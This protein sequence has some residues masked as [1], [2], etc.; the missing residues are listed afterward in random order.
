M[1]QRF[2]DQGVPAIPGVAELL[3]WLDA[4][5]IL[6]AVASNAPHEKMQ[7]T[8]GRIPTVG[9]P[10]RRSAPTGSRSHEATNWYTRFDGRRFS[11]YDIKRWKPH[12]ALFLHVAEVMGAQAQSCIVIEDS[13]SGIKAAIAAGMQV[14]GFADL[15]SPAEL[16]KA[17]ATTTASTIP[18]V[19]GVIKSWLAESA[20]A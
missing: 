9:P 4:D 5:R 19:T 10:S 11:A 20:G 17:G 1:A 12:P 2:E 8:L 6:H 7:L 14:V 18:E 3:D 16:T 13:T 15:S